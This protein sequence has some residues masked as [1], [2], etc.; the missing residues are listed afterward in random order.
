MKEMLGTRS[1]VM[2]EVQTDR[3]L[4]FPPLFQNLRRENKQ[5][6]SPFD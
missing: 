2:L 4:I 3:F 5:H 6:L 1:P